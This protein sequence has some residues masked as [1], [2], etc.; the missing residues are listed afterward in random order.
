MPVNADALELSMLELINEERTSRGLNELQ[1]ERNLNVAAE[2]HSEWMLATDTFS[3]TGIHSSSSTTRIGW[4][5]DLD[6]SWSTAENIAVGS[7]QGAPGYLDDVAS[8]HT[9]LMESAGHRA[10]LLNPNLD[11]I[12]IGIEIGDFVFEEGNDPYRSIM[13]TQ[14]FAST[15]GV[16]DVDPG[17]GSSVTG[18]ALYDAT[19]YSGG[20]PTG[21][22]GNRVMGTSDADG[23]ITMNFEGTYTSLTL[24]LNGYD[25]DTANEV[26]VMLNGESL[27]FLDR[28]GNNDFGLS[29]FTIAVSDQ[30]SGTNTIEFVQGI[31]D[32]FIWGVDDIVLTAP[33]PAVASLEIGDAP[34]GTFGHRVNGQTDEDGRIVMDFDGTIN[35]LTLNLRGYDIDT[36]NEVQVLLNGSSIGYL[37]TTSNNGYGASE[38]VIS[39]D[40]QLNGTNTIEFVQEIND[41]FIWGVDDVS[42][43]APALAVA[44]L[45]PFSSQPTGAFGN[46]VDGQTDGD[47]RVLMNFFSNDA[48]MTLNLRGY[49]ID[50][51]D[52]VQVF[53]NG[54][55]IGF[56]D[57]TANN[58][59]GVSEFEIAASD[60]VNGVNTIEF[61]QEINNSFAWGVDDVAIQMDMDLG[62]FLF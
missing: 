29:E 47:G 55:S 59:F 51:D 11:Y 52:E 14:N 61:V 18:L 38:F 22:F 46:N 6:G 43:S 33:P 42:L 34:T 19:L 21:I 49:D 1:L 37:G 26:Q 48:D 56:L 60:Q 28:T 3:H 50:F 62:S 32:A 15:Q 13:I 41:S 17:T 35:D 5:F 27:G 9:A 10:N 53:L 7:E 40:D 4:E 44:T 23:S 2:E 39:A 12:G 8:L 30:L 24:S 36:A 20:I 58:S 31:N 16:V 45:N 54:E 57:V 25:I